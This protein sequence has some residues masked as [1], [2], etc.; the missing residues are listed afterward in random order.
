M[1]PTGIVQERRTAPLRPPPMF[2]WPDPTAWLM[3]DLPHK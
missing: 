3:R 2:A 1:V